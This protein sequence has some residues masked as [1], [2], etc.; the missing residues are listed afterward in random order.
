MEKN[1][2]LNRFSIIESKIQNLLVQCESLKNER[3]ALKKRLAEMTAEL[4]ALKAG[5]LDRA[6]E[7]KAL[8]ERVDTLLDLLRT[9]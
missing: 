9:F 5:G 2:I 8:Q 3:D 7:E 1:V 4:E 6:R